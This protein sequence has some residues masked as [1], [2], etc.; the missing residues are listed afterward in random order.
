MKWLQLSTL[1]LAFHCAHAGQRANILFLLSDDQRFDTIHALGNPVL[2]T[3]NLDRLVQQG[4]TFTNAYC[5][6]S[7][8]QA[9]CI[10]SRAMMLTGRSLF[11]ATATPL[12]GNILRGYVM[13][14]ELFRKA[15]YRS[16]GIGKWH[17]D[18]AA[19]ARA[20]DG[21]GPIFF[22]GMGA[23][24]NLAVY[25]YDGDGVYPKEK[26]RTINR[27]S[28]ELFADTAVQILNRS[29]QEPFVLYVAFTA[30]HD[31]RTPP[32]DYAQKYSSKS[33]P[34]PKNFLP[35]HPFDNGDMK[36]RDETLLPTPRNRDA[37]RKEIAAYYA[38]IQHLDGQI[39]RILSALD[40]SGQGHNTMIIF[41]SDHGLA[42][43][44][45]GLLGKQNL[46]EHSV[47]APLILAGPGIPRNRQSGALCYLFDIY[48][49]LCELAGQRIPRTVEGRSL[50]PLLQ[51]IAKTHRDSIFCAYRDVQRMVRDERWKLIHYPKVN[52]TQLFDLWADADEMND[53]SSRPEYQERVLDL[54]VRLQ[55]MQREFGDT[56]IQGD[57]VVGRL[58]PGHSTYGR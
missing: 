18:R 43:G 17:N 39:G 20:F 2:Q 31:P 30:P 12:T 41:A 27:Y 7:M 23:H 15:G 57:T 13:W 53:L 45:H 8:V 58:A 55:K 40:A 29:P 19:F 26:E 21:G 44:S 36:V 11:R 48:P 47:R 22:G 16:Y 33:M 46:Y 14:P 25:A 1:L 6:G 9:V 4:F 38:M 50:V 34:L 56:L 32:D 24:S 51:G 5:M 54:T 49:T 37:L 28:S 42:L 35:Q 52:R 10:P 3:P